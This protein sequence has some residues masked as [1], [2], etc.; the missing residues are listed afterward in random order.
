MQRP[1]RP[2]QRVLPPSTMSSCLLLDMATNVIKGV[3]GEFDDME[4]V[5]DFH[6]IGKFL[7]GCS[8]EPG[9]TIHHAS[10]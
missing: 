2:I 3:T 1:P 6:R 10:P 7:N 5:H 9:E 8:L 4:W